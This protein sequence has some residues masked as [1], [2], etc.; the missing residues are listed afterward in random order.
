MNTRYYAQKS[1][2]DETLL[3]VDFNLRTGNI[4][5]LSSPAGA[6]LWRDAC[7][8]KMSSLQDLGGCVAV[9]FHRL[10]PTVNKV[11]SLRDLQCESGCKSE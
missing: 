11:L 3:T 7:I 8:D 9:F 1:R 10:K 4:R 5:S 2:R 6:T